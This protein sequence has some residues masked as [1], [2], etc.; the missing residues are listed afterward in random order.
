MFYENWLNQTHFQ[1]FHFQKIENKMSNQTH[2]LNLENEDENCFQEMKIEN[3][4]SNQM[5]AN[6]YSPVFRWDRH[7]IVLYVL[8]Y[9][10][11]NICLNK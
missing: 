9:A 4:F 2:F 1:Y 5:S 6:I 7:P 10:Y 3:I 11:R 8:K